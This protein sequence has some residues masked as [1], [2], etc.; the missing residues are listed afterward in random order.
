MKILVIPDAHIEED[1]NLK[2]INKLTNLIKL[3]DYQKI[4]IIGDFGG[5]DCL[6]A[7]DKNKKLKMENKRYKLQI[8]KINEA[9]KILRSNFKGEII[10]IEG[11]HEE[12]V[13]RHVEV[14]SVLSGFLELEENLDLKKYNI[15]WVPYKQYIE[16]D[17]VLFTHIPMASNGKAISGA[18]LNGKVLNMFQQSVVYGHTHRLSFDHLTRHKSNTI[19]ALSVGCFFEGTHDYMEGSPENYWRGVIEIETDGK[20]GFDFTSHSLNKIMAL[21]DEKVKRPYNKKNET[22]E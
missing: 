5:F 17:K 4:V 2:R 21:K 3:M 22:K 1:D 7:W 20:G 13:K 14:N 16:I 15:N 19:M 18:N 8:D 10:Y 12:R 11:N 6:S 9:L